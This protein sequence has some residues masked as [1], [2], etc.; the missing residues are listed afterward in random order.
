MTP[1]NRRSRNI[2]MH[3]A[4]NGMAAHERSQPEYF[5][6]MV[7]HGR[8]GRE[9]NVDPELT[10]ADI[11]DRIRTKNYGPIAFIHRV[12]DGECEDVTNELLREAGFYTEPTMRDQIMSKFDQ[13]LTEIDH[14]R[15]ERKH[16]VAK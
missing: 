2:A 14:R 15:D 1:S 3:R 13:V 4:C 7:D 12:S 6:I 10:R 11:V 8:R 16:E 9:A 5:V